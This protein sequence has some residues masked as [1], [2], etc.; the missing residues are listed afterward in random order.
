MALEIVTFVAGPI[1]N[2][3]YLVVDSG[4]GSAVV[5]DPS[6][7][8]SQAAIYAQKKGWQIQQIWLT[9]AHFDH[10]AGNGELIR[11]LPQPVSTALHSADLPLWREM[12]GAHDFGITI[13]PGP[14]PDLLLEDHQLLTLGSLTFQV[15]HTP[16][17]TPGCVV[18][19]CTQEGV[20]FCGDTI[21]RGSVGRA[22][23]PGSN[24]QTLLA[25]VHTRI[26]T[27]SPQTRLLPGHGEETTVANEQR[28]NPFLQNL[29]G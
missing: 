8:A 28:T 27:L 17:H 12:G 23:F 25:S 20:A 4:S 21:F 1:E 11:A 14:K 2:N 18:F 22:D 10:F 7:E 29:P 26:L 16:G 24:F 6:F 19:H 13:D 3:T 15:L 9:H 5:I